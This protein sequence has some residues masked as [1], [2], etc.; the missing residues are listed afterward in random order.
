MDRVHDGNAGSRRLRAAE[1]R[2]VAGVEKLAPNQ[3]EEGA[4]AQQQ[5][6]DGAEGRQRHPDQTAAPKGG[7]IE[8]PWMASSRHGASVTQPFGAVW[9]THRQAV[10]SGRSDRGSQRAAPASPSSRPR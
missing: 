5:R 7:V 8:A 10:R 4:E 3:G 9:L 1:L 2:R 6:P